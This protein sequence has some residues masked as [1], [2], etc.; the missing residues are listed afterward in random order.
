[1]NW[2]RIDNMLVTWCIE[3]IQEQIDSGKLVQPPISTAAQF[4]AW[5]THIC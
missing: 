2:R 4:N 3:R 5:R 1:M